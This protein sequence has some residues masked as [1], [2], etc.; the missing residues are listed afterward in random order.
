MPDEVKQAPQQAQQ[1]QQPPAMTQDERTIVQQAKQIT[2]MGEHIAGLA[3]ANDTLRQTNL[4][5]GTFAQTQVEALAAANKALDELKAGQ[6]ATPI[7]KAAKT[8]RKA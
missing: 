4:Q 6:G 5:L 3:Q 7:A 2:V 1:I 8:R